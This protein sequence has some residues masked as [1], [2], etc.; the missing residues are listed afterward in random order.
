MVD[1]WQIKTQSNNNIFPLNISQ[2]CNFH[3]LCFIILYIFITMS[4]F[5]FLNKNVNK[6]PLLA[7]PCIDLE[8]LQWKSKKCLNNNNN[9]NKINTMGYSKIRI[10][11]KAG[12]VPGTVDP[13]RQGSRDEGL[14]C[15]W[16][17][18][19]LWNLNKPFYIIYKYCSHRSQDINTC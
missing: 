12:D 3:L 8:K 16:D 9:N 14:W 11:M 4:T 2:L 7:C 19:H 10:I 15:W 17:H 13:S 1:R 18:E 5:W 6:N